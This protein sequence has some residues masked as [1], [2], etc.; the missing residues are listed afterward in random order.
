MPAAAVPVDCI[1]GAF[2]LMPRLV[3][4]TVGGMDA[5]YFLHVED[6]D[7]CLRVGREAG[8][9][10]FDPA[11]RIRHRQGTSAAPA[12]FVEWHKARGFIRYFHKH[13]RQSHGLAILACIDALVLVRFLA[14]GLFLGCGWAIAWARLNMLPLLT[15]L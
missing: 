5:G 2:M 3:F 7:F 6:A 11:L 8:V 13:F 9:V 10:L 14:R 1:S 15:I 12:L 4:E